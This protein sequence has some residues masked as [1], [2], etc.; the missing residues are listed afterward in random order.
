MADEVQ[1]PFTLHVEGLTPV[2]LAELRR[3]PGVAAVEEIDLGP[4]RSLDPQGIQT[5]MVNITAIAGSAIVMTTTLDKLFT[6]LKTIATE[7]GLKA[8]IEHRR[9]DVPLTDVTS[10]QSAEIA[11]KATPVAT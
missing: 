5:A 7:H 8:W 11:T 10:E 1:V 9:H 6:Q 4:S 3:I 2:L